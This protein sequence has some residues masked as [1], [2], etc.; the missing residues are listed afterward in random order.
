[1]EITKM[2]IKDNYIDDYIYQPIERIKLDIFE[3]LDDLIKQFNEKLLY[4]DLEKHE[5][6]LI[7]RDLNDLIIH[8]GM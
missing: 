1:M 7:L 6:K 2:T 4:E 8:L 3:K 5:F